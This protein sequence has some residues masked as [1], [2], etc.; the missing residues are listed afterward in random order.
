MADWC[1]EPARVVGERRAPTV[2]VVEDAVEGGA[3]VAIRADPLLCQ[4][5][6]S[7]AMGKGDDQSTDGGHAEHGTDPVERAHD[8][9]DHPLVVLADG[10]LGGDSCRRDDQRDTDAEDHHGRDHR[11]VALLLGRVGD[12]D[13]GQGQDGHTDDDRNRRPH[14][15]RDPSRQAGRHDLGENRG[16]V[17]E[18]GL[19][20]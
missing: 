9:S 12:T 10:G 1:H 19:E 2:P 20:W 8:A 11:H 3:V 7:P 18:S 5:L 16:Q 14:A 6:D 4:E 13:H 15:V 17:E